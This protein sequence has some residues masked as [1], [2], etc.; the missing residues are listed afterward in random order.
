MGIADRRIDETPFLVLDVETTGLDVTHE[1][2]VEL[3]AALV[4]PGEAPRVLIDT[5]VRPERA[6]AATA[7]H[8]ITED[9]VRDAPR[10]AELADAVAAL[11]AGRVVAGHNVG[12]DLR[13]L[14][15]EFERLGREV[16]PP[17]VCTMRLPAIFDRPA[18]WPLWWACQR[19]GVPFDGHA[20]SARGDALATAELL[21]VQLRRLRRAGVET[22]GQLAARARRVRAPAGF[23]RSFAR[24]PLPTPPRVYAAAQVKLRP[25]AAGEDGVRA[26][27]PARRYLD[28]VVRAVARLEVD[29]AAIRALADVRAALGLGPDEA[30][31]V[32]ARIL[33]GAERRYAEDGRIDADEAR[34]LDALRGCLAALD[35][36]DAD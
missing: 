27:S 25:R 4:A 19:G 17:H 12:F 24:D 16:R 36:G 6:M 18:N 33:A 14:Q 10:F 20:H 32:H 5:L 11:L 3:C 34:N 30:R 2:V 28:A 35:P 13:F 9:D 7:I 26:V 23:V 31:A 15:M 21:R 22:F 8:G 29:D 1:R